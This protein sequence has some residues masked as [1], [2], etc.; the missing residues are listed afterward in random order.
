MSTA[1][2]DRDW[3]AIIQTIGAIRRVH[4]HYASSAGGTPLLQEH[5]KMLKAATRMHPNHSPA[6]H[7]AEAL[8]KALNIPID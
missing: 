4:D 8:S 1:D 2:W 6:A 7:V 5:L 3:D